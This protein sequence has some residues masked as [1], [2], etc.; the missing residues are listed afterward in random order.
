MERDYRNEELQ[1][2]RYVAEVKRRGGYERPLA[3]DEYSEELEEFEATVLEYEGLWNT[4]NFG[5]TLEFSTS[6]RF[7][8]EKMQ[9][10]SVSSRR[11]KK[12]AWRTYRCPTCKGYDEDTPIH[13]DIDHSMDWH[14]QHEANKQE[15]QIMNLLRKKFPRGTIHVNSDTLEVILDT[16]EVGSDL[17]RELSL[18]LDEGRE[19]AKL[20]TYYH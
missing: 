7:F 8:E 16:L 14:E 4:C 17:Y 9:I 5:Y 19:A 12:G 20:I 15:F 13:V 18:H 10:L 1:S 3:E 6:T 11:I 2:Q